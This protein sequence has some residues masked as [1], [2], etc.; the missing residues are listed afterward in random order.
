MPKSNGGKCLVF[1]HSKS[2][3]RS[4]HFDL[5]WIINVY[6]FPKSKVNISKSTSQTA[7]CCFIMLPSFVFHPYK[8]K[9]ALWSNK[10]IRPVLHHHLDPE[11][12]D[13]T[14]RG[15]LYTLQSDA[16]DTTFW[17]LPMRHTG[18]RNDEY[19]GLFGSKWTQRT[20]DHM[21]CQ[22]HKING[23]QIEKNTHGHDD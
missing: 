10:K 5:L 3:G 21:I 14:P 16:A 1:C 15:H 18:P 19:R 23:V 9:D 17:F 7:K 4:F 20:C 13:K 8:L 2:S 22:I 12:G 11:R 6:R